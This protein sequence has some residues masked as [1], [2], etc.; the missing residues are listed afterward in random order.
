MALA[1]GTVA[2]SP[3]GTAIGTGLAK[4]IYDEF[5]NPANFLLDTG[6]PMPTG[7]AGVPMKKNFAALGNRLASAIVTHITANAEVSLT[8]CETV[9]PSLLGFSPECTAGG[10]VTSGGGANSNAVLV[11][12]TG[13]GT[14]T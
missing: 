7:A 10:V 9:M 14:V 1:A 11:P 2:V 3:D 12:G 4:A 5:A 6:V 13:T 8:A